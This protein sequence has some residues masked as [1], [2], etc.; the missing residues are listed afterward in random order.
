M[1]LKR[2]VVMKIFKKIKPHS[3]EDAIMI[4]ISTGLVGILILS[5][6]ISYIAR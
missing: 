2:G 1:V 4:M 5:E 6:M 3:I